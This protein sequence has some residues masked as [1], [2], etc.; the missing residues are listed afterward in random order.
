MEIVAST[1]NQ[2]S[3]L[4]CVC[5]GGAKKTTD[6]LSFGVELATF[7]LRLCPAALIIVMAR[8]PSVCLSVITLAIVALL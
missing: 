6:F 3:C 2:H 8:L 1:K 4:D 7:W 5:G